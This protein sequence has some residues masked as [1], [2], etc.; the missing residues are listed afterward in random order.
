MSMRMY[1]AVL[2]IRDQRRRGL[3][4]ALIPAS[5]NGQTPS[6]P[7][8]IGVLGLLIG[9]GFDTPTALTAHTLDYLSEHPGERQR[10]S[11]SRRS[12]L[13][14]AAEEILRFYTPAP[15]RHP[16]ISGDSGMPAPAL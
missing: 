4:A 2:E 3:I 10:L 15:R 6:D 8:I 12:L 1:Q 7:E 13:D 16:T 11:R 14:S 9:G 5:I